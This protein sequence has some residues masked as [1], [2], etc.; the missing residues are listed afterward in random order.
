M[1]PS[2]AVVWLF[3]LAILSGIHQAVADA[4]PPLPNMYGEAVPGRIDRWTKIVDV[5]PI[6]SAPPNVF[7]SPEKFERNAPDVLIKLSEREY[8]F[9]VSLVRERH[10]LEGPGNRRGQGVIEATAMANGG[11]TVSCEMN[12]STACDYLS[13]MANDKLGWREPK[14]QPVRM[15]K[16]SI[17]C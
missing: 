6:T 15:L 16:R 17:G 11:K 5:G 10:C 9:F 3:T 13:A 4:L 12:H 7:I 2:K 14:W 1:K 8:D